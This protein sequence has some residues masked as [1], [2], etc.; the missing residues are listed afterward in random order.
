MNE[1]FAVAG[2]VVAG[3][4]RF[5]LVG[6]GADHG[7]GPSV[8]DVPVVGDEDDDPVLGEAEQVPDGDDGVGAPYDGA[9]VAAVQG[10]V[11]GVDDGGRPRAGAGSASAATTSGS[12][13]APAPARRAALCS[14]T[15]PGKRCANASSSCGLRAD[16]DPAAEAGCTG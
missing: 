14:S 7:L 1:H 13:A 12:T 4:Q 5:S 16:G 11:D 15:P 9:R 2:G 10:V 8:D 6:L 3:R